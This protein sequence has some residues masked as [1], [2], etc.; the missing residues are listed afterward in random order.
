MQNFLEKNLAL[1]Y[2]RESSFSAIMWPCGIGKADIWLNYPFISRVLRQ[3]SETSVAES[4]QSSGYG[5]QNDDSTESLPSMA[6]SINS[7]ED[8]QPVT[9]TPATLNVPCRVKQAFRRHSSITSFNSY[10]S[11]AGSSTSSSG[12]RSGSLDRAKARAN[13]RVTFSPEVTVAEVIDRFERSPR[14]LDL[15]LVPSGAIA[16]TTAYWW[17]L[18]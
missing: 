11:Q 12:S 5:S 4:E 6:G 10:S 2:C 14:R 18:K 15:T 16:Q 1:W 9:S 17:R 7:E 13:K 3:C 8:S